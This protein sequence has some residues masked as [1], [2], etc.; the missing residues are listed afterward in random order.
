[1]ARTVLTT[2]LLFGI[3]T[4]T[5]QKAQKSLTPSDVREAQKSLGAKG[6]PGRYQIVNP[7]P[8][9]VGRTMLLDTETGA[10]W[11]VCGKSDALVRAWCSIGFS[12]LARDEESPPTEQ[13]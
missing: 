12:E 11:I 7:T 6:W 13:Q 1:M 4:R 3:A 2:A 8:Q 5:D 10:T 9:Y